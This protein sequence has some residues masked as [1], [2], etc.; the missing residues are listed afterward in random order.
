MYLTTA[1][2]QDL[3]A[4]HGFAKKK[5]DTGSPESQITLFTHRINHLTSHLQ[6]YKKD[7][8]TQQGLLKLVGKR[9]RLLNYLQRN[10]INR[11]R[12][13]LAELDLRK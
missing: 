9:K 12:A 3:F 7:F 2:K 1:V 8:A 4:K 13:I 11:Y 10:D 5:T 6:T